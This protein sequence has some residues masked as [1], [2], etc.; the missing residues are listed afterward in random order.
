MVD[1]RRRTT[2]RGHHRVGERVRPAGVFPD[3]LEGH[4][5]VRYPECLA[6]V[7]GDVQRAPT[8]CARFGHRGLSSLRT[9]H[10]PY[11]TYHAPCMVPSV[12][13][14]C[15]YEDLFTKY[16]EEEFC[17]LRIDGVLRSSS[18]RIIHHDTPAVRADALSGTDPLR[19]P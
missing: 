18:W 9:C 15:I 16:V 4:Q 8:C 2:S 1:V 3:C 12:R 19:R 11:E 13:I 17:E 14:R 10:F 5:L 7:G 6:L